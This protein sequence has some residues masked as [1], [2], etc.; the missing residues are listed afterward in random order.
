MQSNYYVLIIVALTG[1]LLS[2]CSNPK[3]DGTT[4]S[5]PEGNTKFK[6]YYIQGEQLYTRHCSNCH[7][8]NGTGLG[9]LFPPLN[10]SDYMEQN[11]SEVLC[12][13]RHGK[14]GEL[15]VN[16]KS[17]NK[18][19]PPIPSLTDLEIAEIATYIYNTWNHKQGIIDVR[20]ATKV[21]SDCKE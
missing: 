4:G 8:K 16:G 12:L 19:M 18:A 7:Q 21:L 15:V 20:E 3:Q 6:Q 10:V 9:L 17:F 11:Q 5:V 14:Q 1:S 13:M 2:S